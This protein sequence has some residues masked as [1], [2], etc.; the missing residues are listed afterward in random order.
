MGQLAAHV[1]VALIA[2]VVIGGATRVMEAGLACPDWPLCYGSFLPGRQMNL[3]VFLEWFHRLDAFFV[4]IVLITQFVFSLCWA[5]SLPKWLPWTYGFLTLLV[6]LQGFL[7]ALTVLQLLPSLVI[8]AHLVVAFTL[9]AIM[10]GVTQQL[11]N[12]GKPIFPT[13]LRCFGFL[14]LFTVIAQSLLGSRVAT[15]W[16][17]QRC[18][19]LGESCNLLG[20]HRVSAIP[21]SFLVILFVIVSSLQRD[22]FI[23]QWPYLLTIVFLI[24]AQILLGALSIHLRMSEPSLIIGHQ[25]IACLLVAVIAAL[26]FKGRGNV[27][28]SQSLYITQSTLETCHG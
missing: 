24:I 16:A 17:A 13:W 26:N 12:P 20:L 22:V 6:S 19:D 2:L 10:S 14:S 7:G 15:S 3:Q 9:V 21:V 8:M 1:V 5:K 4:G 18:L 25:L 27:D 28:Y 11:L 23:K